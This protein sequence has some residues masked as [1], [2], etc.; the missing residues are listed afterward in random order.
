MSLPRISVVTPSYNQGQYLE[1][2]L[3]S[4]LSQAYPNLE[5]I[6]IDGGSTD[7]TLEVLKRYEG[8]L[9]YC[10]S[11]PDRGQSDAINKGLRRATGEI[12]TWLG[13]DDLFT[14][15]AL[16]SVAHHFERT[17]A[18]LIHGR[19][20][21]FGEG[22]KEQVK[23]ADDHDLEC[24][25]L[26]GMPFAQP[27]SFFRRS[28]LLEQG[29]LDESLH[30]GMDYDLLARIALNY[31]IKKVED[32]LSKYRLH[33][34]SKSVSQNIAFTRDWAKTFSRLLRSFDFTGD[35]IESLAAL[36]LYVEGEDCYKVTRS[37]NRADLRKAFLY[38]LE[39]QLFYFYENLDLQ[40]AHEL[41]SFIKRS[42]PAFYRARR[43][44][45]IY[46]RSKT[47]SPALVRFLRNFT[48]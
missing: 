23:G 25:Y 16:K 48:R 39:F 7:S 3:Q 4:V 2:T 29:Y 8:Q 27:S 19:T 37:F 11:E 22:F 43:L 46:W 17:D 31:P 6:V 30:Y 47:K 10:M 36:G 44:D 38:F 34:E 15:G 42:D 18:A 9:A 28:V 32:T 26:S 13:S 14:P 12:V 35:L 20:L 1:E 21:L 41:T 40:K 45:K 33:A 5:Y 24:R